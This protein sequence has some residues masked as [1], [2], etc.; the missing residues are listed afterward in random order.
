YSFLGGLRATAQ[1]LSYEIPLAIS[2]M[3]VLLYVGTL[4]VET[5]VESQVSYAYGFIPRWNIFI[6]PV[7]AILF[8]T[9]IF[10]EANRT[11]FDLAE[12]ESELV[13]GYH[14]EY[15]SMKFALF[16]LAEYA[17]MITGAAVMVGIFLGGWHLPWIDQL[18]YNGHAQPA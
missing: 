18:I 3:A 15:S 11:P 2:L 6:H 9:A 4:N 12:C 16:F 5:M 10:A 7:A 8:T 1:M 17:A 13:G 14:T